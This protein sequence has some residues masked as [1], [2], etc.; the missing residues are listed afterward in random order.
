MLYLNDYFESL[1]KGDVLEADIRQQNEI[2]NEALT[3]IYCFL[4]NQLEG[5]II[6]EFEIGEIVHYRQNMIFQSGVSDCIYQILEQYFRIKKDNGIKAHD[7]D[8]DNLSED[9]YSMFTLKQYE[10]GIKY[11]NTLDLIF[12]IIYSAVFK[13]EKT[14]N[15]AKKHAKVMLKFIHVELLSTVIIEVFRDL[16]I[17]AKTSKEIHKISLYK[18][19]Y[20]S[21]TL[22]SLVESFIKVFRREKKSKYMQIL[23]E[24][25]VIDDNPFPF[26]QDVILNDLFY[27]NEDKKE[28][29][30]SLII[31][32]IELFANS[33][34]L[35]SKKN[36]VEVMESYE[37]SEYEKEEQRYIIDQLSLEANLIHG[38]TDNLTFFNDR[39]PADLLIK[40]ITNNKIPQK[41]RGLLIR[42][43]TNLYV[44]DGPF[45]FK[46]M[47]RCFKAY[48]PQSLYSD[49]K[50]KHINNPFN[51]DLREDLLNYYKDYFSEFADYRKEIKN[52]K[53]FEIELI[54]CLKF[55]FNFEM[56]DF[57][58][59]EEKFEFIKHAFGFLC[60]ILDRNTN[61]D[62]FN[63]LKS[64]DVISQKDAVIKDY[65]DSNPIQKSGFDLKYA[66]L[67]KRD[68]KNSIY[69]ELSKIKNN[70]SSQSMAISAEIF[71]EIIELFHFFIDQWQDYLMR[72]V[73][74]LFR[75]RV[76]NTSYKK[77]LDIDQNGFT[78]AVIDD[79]VKEFLSTIPVAQN[80]KCYLDFSL[81][82]LNEKYESNEFR[83]YRKEIR[84]YKKDLDIHESFPVLLIDTFNLS[85]TNSLRQLTL[86]LI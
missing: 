6:A 86:T 32:K 45:S 83:Q 15:Q 68:W 59:I 50:N 74:E 55:M 46:K 80:F 60:Y 81:H 14:Q 65:N 34:I 64:L 22:Q 43:L 2:I 72:N 16:D 25:C 57:S 33:G 20:E 8:S 9:V 36:K 3:N 79:L 40:S 11:K 38:R 29:D 67:N 1:P 75:K 85:Q 73:V 54:R 10:E 35:F 63:Q 19:I 82:S 17:E 78:K 39:Y 62:Y 44:D 48:E 5:L 4:T 47:E 30:N 7:E 31:Y 37:F 84:K 26:V 12:A 13:N 61:R 53:R 28:K 70:D 56:V 71:K 42:I 58:E 51:E 24:I 52:V 18:R 41:L 23:S 77:H 49:T 76:M 21:E 69:T 66:L 27:H